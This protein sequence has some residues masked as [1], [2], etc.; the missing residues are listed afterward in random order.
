MNRLSLRNNRLKLET[1]GE[2]LPIILQESMGEY[3][4]NE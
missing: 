2:L 1:S 3:T 4:S